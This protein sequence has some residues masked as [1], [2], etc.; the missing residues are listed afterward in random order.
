MSLQPLSLLVLAVSL[1]AACVTG[2]VSPSGPPPADPP[3]GETLP[4][5]VYVREYGSNDRPL[6]GA[7]VTVNEQVAG[8]TDAEG[9]AMISVARGLL[10]TIRVDYAGY[11]GFA[12][13]GTVWGPSE[14]WH[15]WLE[16]IGSE[17]HHAAAEAR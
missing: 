8:R 17:E 3:P 14:S 16:R 12:A 5:Q 6:F 15:F 13:E 4:V 7:I 2:P 1:T 11:R 10:V 9:L